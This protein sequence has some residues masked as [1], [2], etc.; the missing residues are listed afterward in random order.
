MARRA[1]WL[2]N[3]GTNSRLRLAQ[4][5]AHSFLVTKVACVVRYNQKALEQIVRR[6]RNHV[7]CHRQLGSNV[8]VSRR[9]NS[10]FGALNANGN[11]HG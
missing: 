7:V 4:R 6:E 8:V 2:G 9:V 5:R 11:S 1:G 10:T 3:L